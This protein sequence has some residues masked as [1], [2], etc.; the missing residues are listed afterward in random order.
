VSLV[1]DTGLNFDFENMQSGILYA[2]S[3]HREKEGRTLQIEDCAVF[4]HPFS[5]KGL[6]T[7]IMFFRALKSRK[8]RPFKPSLSLT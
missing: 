6:I 4:T 8:G 2:T 3:L 1:Q 7:A 5:T